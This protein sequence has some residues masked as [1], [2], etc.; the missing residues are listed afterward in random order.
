MKRKWRRRSSDDALVPSDSAEMQDHGKRT[1]EEISETPEMEMAHLTFNEEG[2]MGLDGP[3]K[4]HSIETQTAR[5]KRMRTGLLKAAKSG[6]PLPEWLQRSNV[7]SLGDFFVLLKAELQASSRDQSRI[8]Q[9]LGGLQDKNQKATS[10]AAVTL[11][12]VRDDRDHL[13]GPEEGVEEVVGVENRG[14]VVRKSQKAD[15]TLD[16]QTGKNVQPSKQTLVNRRRFE[17]SMRRG[18]LLSAENKS[19]LPQWLQRAQA[20]RLGDFFARLKVELLAPERDQARISRLLSEYEDSSKDH[21]NRDD[22][23]SLKEPEGGDKKNGVEDSIRFPQ[24]EGQTARHHCEDEL[25]IASQTAAGDD[26]H[27]ALLSAK[28]GDETTEWDNDNGNNRRNELSEEGE[29]SGSRSP[30]PVASTIQDS[31]APG[32]RPRTNSNDSNGPAGSTIQTGFH[33]EEPQGE[34]PF[35][36]EPPRGAGWLQLAGGLLLVRKPSV[37]HEHEHE[38]EHEHP[39]GTSEA[40]MV[41]DEPSANYEYTLAYQSGADPQED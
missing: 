11:S 30:L 7:K 3:R 18:Y 6:R 16:Q 37:Q 41:L 34:E 2:L 35:G 5:Q 4:N 32:W 29:T 9:M 19:P 14:D 13:T 38:H 17:A 15:E 40:A 12:H 26:G 22:G 27:E 28:T 39:V 20:E 23:A 33:T 36:E 1:S 21:T 8:S 10:P 25:E 31:H 24:N